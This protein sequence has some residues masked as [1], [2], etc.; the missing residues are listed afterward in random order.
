MKLR[1][2][3][4]LCA[5]ILAGMFALAPLGVAKAAELESPF[6][7]IP[8]SGSTANGGSF[9]GSFTVKQFA[10]Q[11]G[12]LVAVGTLK[13]QLA[14]GKFKGKVNQEVALPVKL[15]GQAVGSTLAAAPGGI[16]A[17]QASGCEILDLQLGPLDLT[18]LGLNVFLDE[19]NLEITAIPGGGLLGDLLCAVNNLLN[20]LGTL[21]QIVQALNNLLAFFNN[22]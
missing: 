9:K 11:N 19:V 7:N 21:T 18:L 22:L 10:E 2:I 3:L 20:P 17:F 6:K 16:Q 12:Q 13:G 8:I 1:S 4:A 15:N 14:E 5:L